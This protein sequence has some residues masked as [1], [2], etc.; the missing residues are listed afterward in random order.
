MT[1]LTTDT[2]YRD[3]VEFRERWMQTIT[4][5][6]GLFAYDPAART[7]LVEE[8]VEIYDYDP[9]WVF[10]ARF[11]PS[12]TP[13]TLDLKI[14]HH[15][16]TKRVPRYGSVRVRINGEDYR[17]Q[18]YSAPGNEYHVSFRDDTSGTDTYPGGRV[19]FIPY[20]ENYDGGAF[21]FILDLNCTV[22]GP[23]G[24]SLLTACALPPA[25][26]TIH[27]AVTAGEKITAWMRPAQQD[28]RGAPH[29]QENQTS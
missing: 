20:P 26:N 24:Y 21:D 12:A 28:S 15:D 5:P 2:A 23:C 10:P 19:V 22:N 3:W 18:V 13:E 6:N 1:T 29:L 25:S 9:A 16:G 17:L 8:G 7:H 11:E 14:A 27:S 4:S